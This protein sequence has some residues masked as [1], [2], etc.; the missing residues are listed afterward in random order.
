MDQPD[1]ALTDQQILAAFE[2]Y[3]D[4]G[5]LDY[6]LPTEPLGEEWVLGMR[7]D[8]VKLKTKNEAMA[9]LAGLGCMAHWALDQQIQSQNA[10][11]HILERMFRQ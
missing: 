2:E 10:Q 7:G 8:I 3:A 6:V 1:D 9:C 5:V 4:K 11:S